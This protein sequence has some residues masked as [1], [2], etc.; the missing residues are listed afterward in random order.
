MHMFQSRVCQSL[1]HDPGPNK[2]CIVGDRWF[3]ADVLV[4]G[5]G[6]SPALPRAPLGALGMIRL[7]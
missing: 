3:V 1:A 2:M 7:Q 4:Q 6:A 5:K